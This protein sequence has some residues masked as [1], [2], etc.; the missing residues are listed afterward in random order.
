[1]SVMDLTAEELG[2]ELGLEVVGD[3]DCRLTEATS[4]E[5]ATRGSLSFMRSSKYSKWLK[6]TDASAVIVPDDIELPEGE[7]TYLKSKNPYVSFAQVLSKYYIPERIAKGISDKACVDASAKVGD[8]MT[9][10]PFVFID[11]NVEIGENCTIMSGVRIGKNCKIG[12]DCVLHANV[13][14]EEGTVVGDRCY[15]HPGV[16]LGSEGFGYT[17][18]EE[19]NVKL[20][21]LGSVEIGD[22]VEIGANTTVDK[23]ALSK[24]LIDSGTKID[25][26]VQIGHGSVL[27][28]HN[29]LCSQVGIAG[30][31][32]S[33]D[34]VI[35][36]SRAGVGDHISIGSKVTVGPMAGVT[37]DLEDGVIVSGFPAMPHK[38]WLKLSSVLAQLPALRSQI[39]GML[40][41]SKGS[42]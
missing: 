29:V 41:Q 5:Q 19:G 27:G 38:D 18:T 4:L 1:M 6:S 34:K 28:K 22:D 35:F 40:S 3:K 24:T 31:V 10:E 42:N 7:T 9:I 39:M 25:N 13:V 11:E 23:G 33:G 15:F 12:S 16:V 20:P 26:Q 21:H 14:L 17:Q 36:A 37:K 8:G 30:S 2:V 32:K